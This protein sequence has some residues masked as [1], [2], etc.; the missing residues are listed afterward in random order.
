MSHGGAGAR[1][2][3]PGLQRKRQCRH[4]KRKRGNSQRERGSYKR[5]R[6]L[7][8]YDRRPYEDVTVR[9]TSLVFGPVHYN[10]NFPAIVLSDRQGQGVRMHLSLVYTF[11]RDGAEQ[12][13]TWR[14]DAVAEFTGSTSDVV[15][16]QARP[17][18]VRTVGAAPC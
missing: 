13:Y 9:E 2:D 3:I 15:S 6:A 12:H 17:T 18:V 5:D 16:L 14:M 4:C 11:A 1:Y 8:D 7:I 10:V